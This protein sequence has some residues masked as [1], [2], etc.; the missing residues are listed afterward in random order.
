MEQWRAARTDRA[1]RRDPLWALT[2]AILEDAGTLVNRLQSKHANH[3][4]EAMKALKERIPSMEPDKGLDWVSM[5]MDWITTII[6]M[7]NGL[8]LAFRKTEAGR[9][10]L[11]LLVSGQAYTTPRN[12]DDKDLILLRR[13]NSSTTPVWLMAVPFITL[14]QDNNRQQWITTPNRQWSEGRSTP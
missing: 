8:G 1:G 3:F 12:T 10:R 5:A 13:A 4:K 11:V 6:R 7:D 9:K 2:Q 14:E